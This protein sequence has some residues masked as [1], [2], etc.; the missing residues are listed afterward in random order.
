MYSNFENSLTVENVESAL[1]STM[2]INS[3][4][5]ERNKINSSISTTRNVKTNIKV[6]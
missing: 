6:P 3:L 1:K 5:T 2:I 4:N